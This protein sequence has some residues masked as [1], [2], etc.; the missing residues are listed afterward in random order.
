[1]AKSMDE[2]IREARLHSRAN[3]LNKRQVRVTGYG[4]RKGKKIV[5]F[6]LL[7]P[8]KR[9]F[10]TVY[11]GFVYAHL[12]EQHGPLNIGQLFWIAGSGVYKTK[13]GWYWYA[14]RK[15]NPPRGWC[16]CE[17]CQ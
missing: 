6:D 5:L 16:D 11:S 1:M 9:L 15:C 13:Q 2:V 10:N 8:H 14:G 4:E 12:V 7:E 17:L 3:I